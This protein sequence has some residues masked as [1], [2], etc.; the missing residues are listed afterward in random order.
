MQAE[1]AD[2][3]L[4]DGA[5]LGRHGRVVPAGKQVLE[6][7]SILNNVIRW[8]TYRVFRAAYFEPACTRRCLGGMGSGT[9]GRGTGRNHMTS[10]YC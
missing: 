4:L 2:V 3:Q 7:N 1:L 8:R 5:V 10:V 6:M 9:W